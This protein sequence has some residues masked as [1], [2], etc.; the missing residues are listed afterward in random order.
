MTRGVTEQSPPEDALDGD[1]SVHRSSVALVRT[2]HAHLSLG[3][4]VE[5]MVQ[6]LKAVTLRVRTLSVL[7]R[8]AFTYA[9]WKSEH[10]DGEEEHQKTVHSLFQFPS[11]S[12]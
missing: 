5:A 6:H 8:R 7:H 4:A 10:R 9:P 12:V 11:Q 1:G 3:D 2:A